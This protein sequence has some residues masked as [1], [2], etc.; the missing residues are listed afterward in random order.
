VLTLRGATLP[1]CRLETVL[2][3]A[4]LPDYQR[5]RQ[6]VVVAELGHRRLGFVVDALRGQED[7]VIKTLGASLSNV[8]G[9]SGATDRGD[10][11]LVLVLDAS[12]LMDEVLE[13][14]DVLRLSEV[15]S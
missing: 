15:A 9:I 1:I 4:P 12:S 11:R 2:G 10:Q 5:G 3:F 14:V 6:F 8:R 13:A 7:V